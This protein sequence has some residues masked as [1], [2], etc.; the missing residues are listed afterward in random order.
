MIL[1]SFAWA[2]LLFGLAAA[3]WK[4]QQ[5]PHWAEP[6]FVPPVVV[7]NPELQQPMI[8]QEFVSDLKHAKVHSASITRL[9]N[10]NLMAA[11]FA[12][13][14]EGGKNVKIYIARY[15]ENQWGNALAIVK[16]PELADSLNRVI[17]RLGNPLI[18]MDM[19]GKLWCFF[20]T[21]SI[22]GWSTSSINLMH[23]NDRGKSW[24]QP[25]RLITSP[26]LNMSTLLRNAPLELE[27]GGLIVPVYHEFLSRYPELLRVSASGA[28]VDKKRI[29]TFGIQP[30]LTRAGD[31]N[32]YTFVR[33]RTGAVEAFVSTDGTSSWAPA[34][35]TGLPNPDSSVLV[36]QIESQLWMS[37]GNNNSRDRTDLTL[38]FTR[39]LPANWSGQYQLEYEPVERF[40]Y[41]S[42]VQ[43][44]DGVWHL[45]YSWKE[46]NIKHV[47]FNQAWLNNIYEQS[48][49]K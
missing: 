23:S 42:I 5:H 1:K 22:G 14:V 39:T 17:K 46:I 11:W 43:S 21:T 19:R 9:P 10:D 24:S 44:Q 41:P 27:D 33:S 2:T 16:R 32:W 45:V 38:A 31:G 12:G 35:A 3:L 47:S 29:A 8:K 7:L 37:V 4:I 25:H 48:G 40:S 6:P 30:V 36:A 20:V 18:Y 13:S 49:R 28:V 34:P 15:R 26:F